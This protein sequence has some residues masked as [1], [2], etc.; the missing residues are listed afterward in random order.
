M[1]NDNGVFLSLPVQSCVGLLIQFQTPRQSEPYKRTASA[2]QIQSV[3]RTRR[4]YKCNLYL[5]F[6]P[7][8]YAGITIQS[9]VWK[10]LFMQM[11]LN[12]FKVVSEPVRY[13]YRLAVCG[14]D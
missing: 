8:L 7:P 6:I 5:A 11:F 12:T 9:G 14:F 3:S 4:V 13:K 10:M 2:L 1:V